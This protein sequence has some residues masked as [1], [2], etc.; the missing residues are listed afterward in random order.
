VQTLAFGNVTIEDEGRVSG[1]GAQNATVIAGRGMNV[2]REPGTQGVVVWQLQSGEEVIATGRS[3]DREWIRIQIPNRFQGIG[4][5]YAPYLEV[6]GGADSLPTVNANSPAPELSAPEFGPMQAIALETANF[7]AEC[8][9]APPSGLLMQTPSGLP[10]EVRLQ[11]NGAEITFNGAIFLQATAATALQVY[12]LEGTATVTAAG[13]SA[14]A[15]AATFITVTLDADSNA[16]GAPLAAPF[17]VAD[18]ESL[19]IRLLDRQFVLSATPAQPDGDTTSA[20]GFATPTTAAGFGT[21]L[22]TATPEVCTLTAPDVRNVR[23]GPSTDFEIVRVLQAGESVTGIGQTRDVD[24][25]PWYQTASGYIRL[26]AVDASAA[27]ANLP[28]VTPPPTEVPAETDTPEAGV[29]E[30]TTL[31]AVAC[32]GGQVSTSGT[33]DGSELF[34]SLGGEWT[35]GAGTTATFST[36]GGL[37]RPELGSYI[38]LV[39]LD[40]TVIAESNDGRVLTVNFDQQQ[41][42]T[43]RFSAA[44]G[45][46]VVMSARC[47][48]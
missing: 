34:I 27:C 41:T 18:F 11:V 12:V 35:I 43:A 25:F 29:F 44:N 3:A 19:P 38:Q 5:V 14:N 40:G 47:D 21:P 13:T 15:G 23:S 20:E 16:S 10:D 37:L 31:G 36:Q 1:G 17:P 28:S 7:P 48:S 6:E 24:R 39:T 8:T 45:D 32:P 9:A 33:S 2:R 46:V 4:W 30:S 22:P 42:F 26:D